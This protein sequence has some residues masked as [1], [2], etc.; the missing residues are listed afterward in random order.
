MNYQLNP[1]NQLNQLQSDAR[2]I[3]DGIRPRWNITGYNQIIIKPGVSIEHEVQELYLDNGR[4]L[5]A[6]CRKMLQ[7]RGYIALTEKILALTPFAAHRP[8]QACWPSVMRG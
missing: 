1:L 3:L 8:V 7:L 6:D 5:S 4:E 2:S